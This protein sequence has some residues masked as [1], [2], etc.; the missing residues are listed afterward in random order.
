MK[1]DLRYLQSL[2]M[3]NLLPLIP[4]LQ[5]KY[6]IYSLWAVSLGI[7]F[8]HLAYYILRGTKAYIIY[9]GERTPQNLLFFQHFIYKFVI[10][11]FSYIISCWMIYVG[12]KYTGAV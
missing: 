2:I 3:L 8:V 5:T 4:A 12:F 6:V 9:S 1:K 11:F 7:I 10:L